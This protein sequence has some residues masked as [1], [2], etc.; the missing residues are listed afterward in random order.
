MR[1][2]GRIFAGPIM[3]LAGLNHFLNP[4]FY[5]RIIPPLL[6]AP[7]LL[8]YASGA[9]EFLAAVATMNARTR[10]AGG[11]A[12][13]TVLVGVFPANAYMALYPDRFSSI[14]AWALWARL[15]LQP[16]FV[17]L[18]W[19]GTLRSNAEEPEGA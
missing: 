19:V 18:V 4:G 14:P 16:L 3:A 15:A 10:R 13:I 17:Y 2:V 8:V 1:T 6:P 7:T 12:L 5:E 9:A 11:I